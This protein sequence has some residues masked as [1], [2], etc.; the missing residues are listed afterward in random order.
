M[1]SLRWNKATDWR[2]PSTFE[3]EASK[4]KKFLE[5]RTSYLETVWKY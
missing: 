3:D 1:D 5:E 2:T 4:V